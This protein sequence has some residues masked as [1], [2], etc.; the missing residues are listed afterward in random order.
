MHLDHQRALKNCQ[1]FNESI[2]RRK[3]EFELLKALKIARES[4]NNF[5][6]QIGSLKERISCASEELQRSIEER[7]IMQSKLQMAQNRIDNLNSQLR[8]V[9]LSRSQ[10][11]R[12]KFDDT[13]LERIKNELEHEI[14]GMRRQLEQAKQSEKK[15]SETVSKA[16]GRG[17]ESRR[18][19]LELE[20]ELRILRSEN[21][22]LQVKLKN[23]EDGKDVKMTIP[24]IQSNSKRNNNNNRLLVSTTGY[25][26]DNTNNTNNT[27][28][29]TIVD[30]NS[31]NVPSITV[32]VNNS[33]SLKNNS[34]NKSIPI[35]IAAESPIVRRGKR[36]SMEANKVE[37]KDEE[38]S[39]NE[40]NLKT[41]TG[42]KSKAKD[43]NID[44]S[45][46]QE[47][48]V[49]V[50]LSKSL[51]EGLGRKKIKLPERFTGKNLNFN[52]NNSANQISLQIPITP[53]SQIIQ[54]QQQASTIPSLS[55]PRS[56]PLGKSVDPG[57]M[58]SIM[59]S[60]TVKIPTIKK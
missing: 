55:I 5:G 18:E 20:R 53:Q 46:N 50:S 60:F 38:E 40:I 28:N 21:N 59:S 24:S 42:K 22:L 17:D 10:L 4:E 31:I 14:Q 44:N 34:N 54:Q 19:I 37:V 52:S 35:E 6:G 11:E 36:N 3:A 41:P 1:A 25:Y 26:N 12:Q 32:P 39:L 9:E 7:S 57:V 43:Q 58:E 8:E 47:E 30:F 51:L 13:K 23:S 27:N 48:K 16:E 49:S 56:T 45:K 29:N 33:I 2:G 15:L